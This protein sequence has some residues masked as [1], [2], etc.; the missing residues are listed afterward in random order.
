MDEWESFIENNGVKSI[1]NKLKTT[2]SQ[3]ID[4]EYLK[5]LSNILI[6]C[7]CSE[8]KD[9]KL[10][11]SETLNEITGQLIELL[12]KLISY[13]INKSESEDSGNR[14]ENALGK[15]IF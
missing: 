4:I 1:T 15:N 14:E 5:S 11:V 6:K 12:S 8:K 2:I 3:E 13:S 9:P 7:I 10:F